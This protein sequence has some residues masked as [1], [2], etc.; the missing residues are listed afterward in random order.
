MQLWY[1]IEIPNYFAWIEKKT[2]NFSERKT[3]FFKTFLAIAYFNPLWITR[4]LFFIELFSGKIQD[5][6]WHLFIIG[7]YSFLGNI[8]LSLLDELFNSNKIKLTYRFLASAIFSGL[9]AIY[10][11]LSYSIF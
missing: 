1:A 7:F 8:P 10:Y 5:V 4:H 6:T 3:T 11:A 2:K 9:M